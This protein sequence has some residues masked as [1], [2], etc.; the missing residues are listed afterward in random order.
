M[1][2]R[3]H[4]EYSPLW[5]PIHRKIPLIEREDC[6]QAIAASQMDQGC[7]CELY[8]NVSVLLQD[9]SDGFGICAGHRQ[10]F[11]KSSVDAIDQLVHRVRVAA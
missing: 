8:S 4:P 9:G 5:Q 3:N 2:L 10:E 1:R 6:V 7:V 11:E